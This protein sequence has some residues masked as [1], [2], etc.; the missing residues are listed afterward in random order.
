MAPKIGNMKIAKVSIIDDNENAGH[1]M[2][3]SVADAHFNPAFEPGP[4]PDLSAFIKRT[5]LSTDAAICDHR[6]RLGMYAMFDGADAVAEFYTLKFPALLC[7]NFGQDEIDAIRLLRRK[8]PVVLSPAETDP[9]CIVEAFA[10]CIDEFNDKYRASRKPWRT[11]LR[12]E[13]YDV[14]REMLYVVLP[15]WNSTELLR[16]PL[17]MI[18]SQHRSG[19]LPGMRLGVQ[20][21]LGAESQYDLYFDQFEFV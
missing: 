1:S 21:N 3:L 5:M 15:G 11:L 14:R 2:E 10:I 8:I 6:L 12:I 18:P 20:T 19:I 17:K 7:T 9:T 13:D 16:V 4:L